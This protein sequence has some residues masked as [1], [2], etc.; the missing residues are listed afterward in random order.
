MSEQ[1]QPAFLSF[2]EA[3]VGQGGFETDDALAALLPL[4]KQT[5]AAHQAG[6]TLI[7]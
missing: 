1:T 3:G 7:S 5:L 2:L 4:M 6:L